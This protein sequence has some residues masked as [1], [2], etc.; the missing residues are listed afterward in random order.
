MNLSIL[1][2]IAANLASS[3]FTYA[4]STPPLPPP[5]AFIAGP[6]ALF[7]FTELDGAEYDCAEGALEVVEAAGVAAA[8]VAAGVVAAA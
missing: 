8:G 1:A 7:E 5:E 4:G 2:S 3:C 6:E